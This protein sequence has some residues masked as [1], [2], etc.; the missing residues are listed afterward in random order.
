MMLISGTFLE[1]LYEQVKKDHIL[2]EACL[3]YVIK[4]YDK[5]R[6]TGD[7]CLIPTN[8]IWTDNSPTH[9]RCRWIFCN[10]AT[11]A[12]ATS[13]RIHTFGAKYQSKG[14]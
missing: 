6:L 2:H 5:N 4:F 7:L 3:Q 12:T 14:S 9:Y 10:I 13:T 1:I 11:S 8:I